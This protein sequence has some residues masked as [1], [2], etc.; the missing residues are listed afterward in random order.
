MQKTRAPS[1]LAPQTRKWWLEVVEE[2]ELEKHHVRLLTLAAEAW[3]RCTQAREALAASG[4]TFVDRFGTPRAR[5]EVN[6]ERDARVAVARL[7]RELGLDLFQPEDSR[8][9][10]VGGR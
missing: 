10:R 7:T 9:P 1:H 3:D 8:P 4:L 5:P 2:F 6:I